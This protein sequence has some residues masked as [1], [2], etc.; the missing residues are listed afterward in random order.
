MSGRVVLRSSAEGQALWG[1]GFVRRQLKSSEVWV[2]VRVK[3]WGNKPG[4]YSGEFGNPQVRE[5]RCHP[6]AALGSMTNRNRGD[7]EG[8]KA[9]GH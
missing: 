8:Y 5:R 7:I 1:I 6:E 3:L 2:A 4:S 9:A